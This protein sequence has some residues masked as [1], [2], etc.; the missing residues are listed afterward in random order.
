LYRVFVEPIGLSS[1]RICRQILP[2][3]TPTLQQPA[4]SYRSYASL[5]RNQPQQQ[6][7]TP[8]DEEITYDTVRI[9]SEDKKLS[10]PQSRSSILSSL[11]R[12][13]QTLVLVALPSTAQA[14]PI[15]RIENKKQLREAEKAR[16]KKKDAPSATVKTIELNWAIDAHDLKHRMQRL[17]EF[18]GKGWRVEIIMAGKKRGRQATPEEATNCLSAVKEAIV[19][20]DGAKE[21]KTMNGRVG[22]V[23]TIYAE[24]KEQ[25]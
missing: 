5:A 13:T 22:A 17:Q 1:Q 8:R 2:T 14:Y 21:W 16:S 6:R 20:V 24:G 9:V 12:K 19:G 7:R 25:K 18:L 11:D 23:A 10:E 3:R 15:C 4:P